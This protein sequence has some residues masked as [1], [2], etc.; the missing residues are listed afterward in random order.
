MEEEIKSL[1]SDNQKLSQQVGML[2]KEKL[3]AARANSHNQDNGKE[4][5]ELKQQVCMLTKVFKLN[6]L[7]WKKSKIITKYFFSR[8]DVSLT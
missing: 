5:E 2:L 8:L 6:I 3:D 1:I 4:L 7:K